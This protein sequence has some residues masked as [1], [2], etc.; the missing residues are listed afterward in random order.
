[1]KIAVI[2]DIHANLAALEA[3]PEK[4]CDQLWCIGDL[5]DYGP[6]PREVIHWVKD[7]ASLAVRGNHD[8]AVGFAVDPKCSPPYKHLAAETI[9]FTQGV[10]N[11]NDLKFLR[12]LP[13]QREVAAGGGTFY[14]VHAAPT[15][16]LFGYRSKDSELWE[17]EIQWIN[18]DFLVVGHTH[19]PFV[20][21]VGPCTIVNP[22]SIGQ[23]KTGRPQACYALWQDGVVSLK[24]YW[25]PVQ[26]TSRQIQQMPLAKQDQDELIAV[27]ETGGSAVPKEQPTVSLDF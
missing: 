10:C 15:D 4:D 7:N 17:K 1:M 9:R 25:Y 8:H 13:V 5:V 23:P 24:E 6:K 11:G 26:K 21:K 16:P 22:G 14:L 18:A 3:F 19:T 27:L 20:R 2:S 12:E